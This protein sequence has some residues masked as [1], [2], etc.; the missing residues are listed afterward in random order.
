MHNCTRFYNHVSQG[1]LE[2]KEVHV[3]QQV[4][5]RQQAWSTPDSFC[6]HHDPLVFL[7]YKPEVLG[8]GT[9]YRERK[10]RTQL[11]YKECYFGDGEFSKKKKSCR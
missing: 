1:L 9:Y 11:F 10:K 4:T 6:M 3:S 7:I 5:L 8:G 2:P